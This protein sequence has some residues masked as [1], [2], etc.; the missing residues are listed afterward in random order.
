MS[1]RARSRRRLALTAAATAAV[2]LVACQ[3]S[4]TGP[5]Q[6][7]SSQSTTIAR[8]VLV[9]PHEISTGE[10]IQL[11]ANAVMSNYAIQNVTSQAHWAV[12]SSPISA[13]LTVT[14]TGLA[15]AGEVG[16]AVVTARFNGF[17]ADATI[18]VLT[19]GTFSLEGSVSL[20]PVWLD[21]VAVTVISGVGAGLTTRSDQFGRYQLLG[22]SGLVQI[23]ASKDGYLDQTRQANLGADAVVDFELSAAGPVKN[24]AGVYGLTITPRSCGGDVPDDAKRQVYT[25]HIDQTGANLRVSLSDADFLPGGSA[26]DGAVTAPGEIKFIIRPYDFWDW[27]GPDLQERLSDGTVLLT[28]GHINATSTPQGISGTAIEQEG[29]LG[30]ILHLRPAWSSF[31]DALGSC[32]IDRFDMVRR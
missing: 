28:F 7:P 27:T 29:G 19:K 6:G 11:T 1:T 24:Y 20:G 23:R 18:L 21:N 2:A 14:G 31:S 12:Q 30:G 22:V 15:T 26:F 32:Y 17:E 13:A 5:S 16:R 3:K 4:P 25:A 9:A 10:S 8:L